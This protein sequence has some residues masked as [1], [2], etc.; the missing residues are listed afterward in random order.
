MWCMSSPAMAS[1]N[2]LLTKC[3]NWRPKLQRM[4]KSML[5]YTLH[6]RIVSEIHKI[7]SSDWLRWLA[8][9]RNVTSCILLNQTSLIS[10]CPTNIFHN[11]LNQP[12]N[13]CLLHTIQG[14]VVIFTFHTIVGNIKRFLNTM[15]CN[16][17]L[18]M[19]FQLF[20]T[21]TQTLIKKWN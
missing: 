14:S 11:L 9:W 7:Q 1:F 6:V 3:F 19:F 16:M 21:V 18:K 12:C 10:G 8:V 20:T 2:N 17:I 15:T 4:L 13:A 5:L